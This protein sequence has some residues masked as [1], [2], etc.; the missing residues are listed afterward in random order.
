M[1]TP[2][3]IALVTARAARE[4]D[5]DLQPLEDALRRAGADVE[6]ASWDD[7]TVSWELFDL[8][9]LRS[10]WD[11]AE[12]LDEF[13]G[14]TRQV[15]AQTRLVNSMK[16]VA[17]NTD[18]HYLAELAA[19]GVPTVPSEFIEPG[20]SPAA[21]VAIF[22]S[23]YSCAECVVKPAVGAGSRDAQRHRRDDVDAIV[24][25]VHRLLAANRSVL[26]QPYLERV[27]K[28]GETALIYFSG[29]F[30]HAIRK[31]PLLQSGAEATKA[32]YAPEKITARE[33]TKDELLLAGQT[34]GA[35]PF[36][37]PLY[38]RVDLIREA[39]GS[40]RLLELELTEPSLFFEY[41]L[42]S[43][44]RFAKAILSCAAAGRS[45]A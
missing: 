34:L 6:I 17:W 15:S 42:G 28:D 16:T 31:G 40:P 25:H 23:R 1:T 38:A 39:D 8:A 22:L 43:A 11:Y 7:S 2:P 19:A 14:W 30:S 41:A 26:M 44:G 33:P 21:A 12:R 37:L 10:T 36:E 32:L 13:L 9:V 24:A 18:K 45:V 27:D 29:Q 20:N 3:K 35:L 4:T 5:Y